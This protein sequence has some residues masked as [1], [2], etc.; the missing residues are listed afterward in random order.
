MASRKRNVEEL[1]NPSTEEMIATTCTTGL[2]F[3]AAF[4]YA[5]TV[6]GT[7]LRSMTFAERGRVV[8]QNGGGPP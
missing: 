5:R 4:D 7:A 3:D 2:N 8:D 1:F 6:G